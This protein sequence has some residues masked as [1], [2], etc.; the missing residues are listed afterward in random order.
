MLETALFSRLRPKLKE[1]GEFSRIENS[2]ESGTWD[3]FYC[4]DGQQGWIETKV[5]K[6]GHLYFEKFQPNWARRF[7]RAGLDN[8]FIIA[9]LEKDFNDMGVYHVRELLEANREPY[10]KWVRVITANLA[11]QLVLTKPYD[12]ESLRLLLADRFT[13]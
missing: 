1:W 12:W 7:Y 9:A 10:R 4:I 8:M 3:T 6:G 5:E 13:F 11:P 2:V